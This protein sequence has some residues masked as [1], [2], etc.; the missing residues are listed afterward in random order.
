VHRLVESGDRLLCERVLSGAGHKPRDLTEQ[1]DDVKPAGGVLSEG[2]EPGNRQPG[3]PVVDG[4]TFAKDGGANV[5]H[6]EVA[7]EV[8]ASPAARKGAV[9]DHVS[10]G[11]GAS[12]PPLRGIV[13]LERRQDRVRKRTAV[14][15]LLSRSVD[16]PF[17]ARP[18]E[19]PPQEFALGHKV[20]LFLRGLAD[21]AE[22]QVAGR[23][24]ERKT[25]R[26]AQAGRNDLVRTRLPDEGIVTRHVVVLRA[27]RRGRPGE[28]KDA[29]HDDIAANVAAEL[30]CH[31]SSLMVW[32]PLAPRPLHPSR[33]ES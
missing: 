31:W 15:L 14:G 16:G 18:A 17:H 27:Y 13:V 11:D 10:A 23:A 3:R 8:S 22:S 6:V 29:R 26:V 21:V 5:A 32:R 28:H 20:D 7:I 33:L 2:D 24:I 19:V 9:A 4:S 25:G 30:P 12:G 1:R